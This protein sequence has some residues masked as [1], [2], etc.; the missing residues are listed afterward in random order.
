MILEC[1]KKYGK[2]L[3]FGNGGSAAIASHVAVDLTK[4][5]GIKS[6]TFNE[7]D[8]ITCFS[9]D[10]GYKNWM[11]KSLFFYA[12][13]KDLIILISSSGN[14]PNVIAA[15]KYSLQQKIN[16]VTL[17][18]MSKNN[19]LRAINKKGL[20]IWVN[21]KS[22]NNVENLH[23]ILLLSIVDSIISKKK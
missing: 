6:L 10:Y 15:A 14:S 20:N 12:D 18:G 23:Q 9:N 1:K 11:K 17:T 3:I 8:L 4:N 7:V 21:S 2:V 5:A 13:K 19:K 16:F 22:Y